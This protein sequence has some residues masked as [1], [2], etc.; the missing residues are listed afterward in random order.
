MAEKE[1]EEFKVPTRKELEKLRNTKQLFKSNLFKMQVDELLAAVT[2][3]YDRTQATK[4]ALFDVRAALLDLELG[5]LTPPPTDANLVGS[6]LTQTCV[7]PALNVDIGF[8]I[9]PAMVIPK[10]YVNNR[11]PS[12]R[13]AYVAQI[14]TALA[15]A[16]R[17]KSKRY[18]KTKVQTVGFAGDETK[19]IIAISHIGPDTESFEGKKVATPFT[20][21]LIPVLD[22]AAPVFEARKLGPARNNLRKPHFGLSTATPLYNAAILEDLILPG[23]LP[24][25]HAATSS[26]TYGDALRGAIVLAKVWLAK[27]GQG[28]GCGVPGRLAGLHVSL[29]LLHLLISR[30]VPR[31]TS[32]YLLF[33]ALLEFLAAAGPEPQ[34]MFLAL[35]VD[36]DGWPLG[37]GPILSKA[38]VKSPVPAEPDAVLLAAGAG[39]DV[40]LLDPTGSYNFAWRVSASAWSSASWTAQRSL[41]VLEQPSLLVDAFASLFARDLPAVA[42]FDTIIRIHPLPDVADAFAGEE[43]RVTHEGGFARALASR[44]H[45]VLTRGL[46]KRAVGVDVQMG[47]SHGPDTLWIGL[48]LAPLHS[49]GIV[50]MG[51]SA[52]SGELA[53]AFRAFWGAKAE[54]RR[55]VDGSI[56]EAVVWSKYENH[57]EA[58]VGAVVKHLLKLHCSIPRKTLAMLP[59]ELGGVEPH[60]RRDWHGYIGD[61]KAAR[62]AAQELSTLLLGITSLPLD[63]SSVRP[64]SPALTATSAG[65][66]LK[67]GD[68][69]ILVATGLEMVIQFRASAHWPSDLVAFQAMKAGFLIKLAQTLQVRHGL[70]AVLDSNGHGPMGAPVLDVFFADFVFR[71]VIHH[72]HEIAMLQQRVDAIRSRSAQ[73]MLGDD[74]D[75]AD[76]TADVAVA[77]AEAELAA[78][79]EVQERAPE[80][81][82]ALDAFT[83]S[84]PAFPATA[85]AFKAW[86]AG[87]CFSASLP[88]R[89]ADLIVAYAL[90]QWSV[91]GMTV[92]PLPGL[93]RVLHLVANFDWE[94]DP[95]IVRLAADDIAVGNIN[96][97]YAAFK[98]ARADGVVM[99][100]ADA[101]AGPL[102]TLNAPTSTELARLVRLAK[103]SAHLLAKIV[104]HGGHVRPAWWDAIF[105]LQL[106]DFD[107]I[108]TLK[109]APKLKAATGSKYKNLVNEEDTLVNFEPGAW[110]V[111]QLQ[112]RYS[113]LATICYGGRDIIA[114]AWRTDQLAAT[115]RLRPLEPVAAFNS[116]PAAGLASSGDAV[117]FDI[118][119]M[120]ADIKALGGDLVTDVTLL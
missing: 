87:H 26:D 16:L 14:A 99:F 92:S 40:S 114:I 66:L 12:T 103:A 13:A 65:P 94:L 34:P 25:L 58:I 59:V 44:A 39:Y 4:S 78:V 18:A 116:A 61:V 90:D 71:L 74:A 64:A 111:R 84:H 51:P 72:P 37:I 102:V 112:A 107:L 75:E 32:S 1:E 91:A 6:F 41:A 17:A 7:K 95:L 100:I 23:Q 113:E 82:A 55:F 106:A 11:Y 3:D 62:K 43:S 10:D 77:A 109:N 47:G 115:S 93:L 45:S 28:A 19:P 5:P 33:K 73:T 80:H 118:V 60:T 76:A 42:T 89:A 31:S 117:V 22:S 56:C 119:G 81:A 69:R 98:V 46:G 120:V 8:V 79:T 52:D 29:I 49:I 110:L 97:L 104:E 53:E 54:L 30:K 50:D 108:V 15:A 101:S 96:D 38:G 88:S 67:P 48:R 68:G 57:Q 105:N 70:S 83:T 35:P 9:P 27:H 20:I 2:I 63:I 86:L 24:L 85:V 36:D 21:K